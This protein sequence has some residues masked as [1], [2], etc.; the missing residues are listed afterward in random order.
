[1]ATKPQSKSRL[2]VVGAITALGL[3]AISFVGGWEGL[4]T[5][6][7]RDAVGIWT[8]C[9]GETKGV[10]RGVKYTKEECENMFIESGLKR[11]EAGMRKCL[12]DPDAIPTKSYVAFLSLTYNIGTGG[13]CKSSVRRLINAGE[14]KAACYRLMVYNRAGGRVLKGLT[15]RRTAEKKLCLE[16]VKE[17][18]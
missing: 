15:R 13:F 16:G 5:T 4:R 10:T 9:Y 8:V 12:I 7:Y 18:I 3:L 17:G 6:S 14:I 11:H 2:G 1:M